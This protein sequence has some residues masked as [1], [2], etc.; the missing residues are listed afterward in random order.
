MRIA[1]LTDIH[2]DIVALRSALGKAYK[3]GYDQMVCLGDISGFSAPHHSH[4][5]SRDAHG[6]LSYLRENCSVIIGGNHDY[7]A[8]G[9][10]APKECGFTFPANWYEMDLFEREV[11]SEAMVWL[12]D[13][14]LTPWYTG[15]DIE[16]IAK[17]PAESIIETGTVRICLSHFIYPNLCGVKNGFVG[18]KE[19]YMAHLDYISSKGCSVGVAGHMH[20]R[21][22]SLITNGYI[23]TAGSGSTLSIP[24]SPCVIMAPA[25]TGDRGAISFIDTEKMKVKSIR[26]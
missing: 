21:R 7:H 12:Y 26:V 13:D 16:F 14:E 11:V 6:C 1:V 20:P 18:D 2:E 5:N 4:Y 9:V 23:E 3:K 10:P 22:L 19:D 25:V 15:E 8:A 17:L 24:A